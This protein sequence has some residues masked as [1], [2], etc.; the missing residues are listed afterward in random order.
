MLTK[1]TYLTLTDTSTAEF[2]DKG[3]R[4]IAVAYPIQAEQEVKQHL[5]ALKKT[6]HAA[7]HFCYAYVLGFNSDIQKS[8]DDREPANSAG[9]PILRSIVQQQLTNTLVVVVRYFGGKLLG[10]PGLIHAYGEAANMALAAAN[11]QECVVMAR[12]Q[13]TGDFVHENELYKAYKQFDAKMISHQYN[14][15]QFIS[16]YE[17]RKNK[18]MEL[19]N[20]LENKR[21]FEIENLSEL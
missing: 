19:L 9:K 8:N 20:N 6:H 14:Q 11:R 3:S 2:K 16:I 12:Y 13:V 7:A 5:T 10:V 21:L 18:S 17:V 15:H 1:D 4:F